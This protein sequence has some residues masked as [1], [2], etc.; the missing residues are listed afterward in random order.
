MPRLFT[1]HSTAGR[2]GSERVFTDDQGRRRGA[3]LT[4]RDAPCGALVLRPA[5]AWR[6]NSP[7]YGTL[8]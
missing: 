2:A 3:A 6:P 8:P 5:S 4:Q 7:P 1:H